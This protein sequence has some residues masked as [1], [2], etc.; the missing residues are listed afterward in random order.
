MSKQKTI[1]L[2]FAIFTC[3]GVILVCLLGKPHTRQ[4]ITIWSWDYPDDL[5]FIKKEDRI[6]VAY[7][8]GTIYLRQGRCYF[9]PRSK[10]LLISSQTEKYPAIRLES[11]GQPVKY[12]DVAALIKDLLKQEN[13]QRVQLDFDARASEIPFY[14]YLLQHLPSA[15]GRDTTIDITA[16]TS[17][18]T[19]DGVLAK[20]PAAQKTAMCFSLGGQAKESLEALARLKQKPTSIGVSVYEHKTNQYLKTLGLTSQASSIYLYSAVPWQRETLQKVRAEVLCQ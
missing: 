2:A 1:L 9:R 4:T 7:Y 12:N 16:L 8:A 5:R 10:A 3:C 19:N 18:Y 11:D 15:L 17:W 6:K 13:A 14:Q 20:L